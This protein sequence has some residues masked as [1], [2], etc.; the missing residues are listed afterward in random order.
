M[1]IIIMAG[2]DLNGKAALFSQGRLFFARSHLRLSC[3][4]PMNLG[5]GC[6]DIPVPGFCITFSGLECRRSQSF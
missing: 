5:T 6:A 3:T 4:E 1:M 2:D